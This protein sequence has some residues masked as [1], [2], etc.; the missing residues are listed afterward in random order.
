MIAEVKSEHKV[1]VVRE[2]IENAQRY[3]RLFRVPPLFFWGGQERREVD[4]LLHE[5]WLSLPK[6][7]VC[8][9]EDVR[10]IYGDCFPEPVC[11]VC[12]RHPSI[13]VF[14]EF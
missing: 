14:E 12:R 4:R 10:E 3:L 11:F 13:K 8:G 7:L 2:A 9:A 1:S 6:C 5:A